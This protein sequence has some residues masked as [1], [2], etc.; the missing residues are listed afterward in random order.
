[1]IEG[2]FETVLRVAQYALLLGLFGWSAFWLLGLRSVD[3]L[4]ADRAPNF[5]VI[6]ALAAPV[7]SAALMLISIAAMM[8]VP[9]VELDLPMIE[10][11]IL[12][13]DMGFAFLVRSGLLLT[14]LA[15]ILALRNRQAA[16]AFAAG[17][18][19]CALVT[20]GWSGH[21]AATEG[22]L[23]LFHRLNNGIHLVSAGLWLGAIGRFLVLTFRCYK[24]PD[25]AKAHAVLKAMHAF[26]PMGISLVALVAVTG[27][28]NSHLI[29]G[30][31]NVAATFATPYGILLAIKLALV[32]AMVAFGAH[33]ARVS[34]GAATA[35]R[36]GNVYPAQA[37]G[38]LQRTLIAEFL[39]GLL[40]I[41]LVA[42][43]GTMSPTMM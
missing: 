28:V 10:A 4:R 2:F 24:D 9:V 37:L 25:E 13:T 16:L 41:G 18:Y 11:M 7:V 43:F 15:A 21:A 35:V 6:A 33:H 22:G 23:G 42:V 5:A 1:V 34:R 38:A 26:A 39:L 31:P 27:T 30:L 32:A 20:L 40:A 3:W 8:G 36:D 19:G 17:C 14:G 12:G 29:F